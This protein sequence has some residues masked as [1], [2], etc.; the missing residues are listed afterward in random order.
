MGGVYGSEG[1]YGYP[2]CSDLIGD[3]I[4]TAGAS[5]EKVAQLSM[6]VF[7]DSRSN[8]YDLNTTQASWRPRFQAEFFSSCREA[9][10]LSHNFE[11]LSF[12]FRR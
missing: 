12:D 1:I 6:D 7:G 10:F 8:G 2:G 11:L 3:L 5:R 9:T 4:D